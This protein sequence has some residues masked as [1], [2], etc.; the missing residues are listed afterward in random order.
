MPE[1]FVTF[2]AIRKA[3]NGGTMC[4]VH[5]DLNPKLINIYEDPFELIVVEVEAR[6]KG[7]RIITGCGPQ[8]NWDKSKR[9]P[10]FITLE[11]EIIKA[12]LSGKSVII[13][14]DSNSKLGP[15]Y[16]KNDPHIMS[17]NGKI[18]ARILE[19]HTLIVANGSERCA[20]LITR[21]RNTLSRAE[22]SCIDIVMFS[23]DLNEHFK[24]LIIDDQ[25]KHVL[26]RIYKTKNGCEAQRKRS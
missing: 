16:I 8:E 18:L 19:R 6:K 23:S 3:K 7:I 24:S 20:G 26:T 12:E 4:A 25:R 5:N 15:E 14:M 22:R 21:A 11:A 1:G 9:M 2:E 17:P 13:E 10:F